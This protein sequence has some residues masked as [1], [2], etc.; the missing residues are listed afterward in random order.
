VNIREEHPWPHSYK[1]FKRAG[2][3]TNG[4]IEWT[5]LSKNAH[6]TKA[7]L[8]PPDEP[9]AIRVAAT[10]VLL[11]APNKRP[12]LMSDVIDVKRIVKKDQQPI[13]ARRHQGGEHWE[14]SATDQCVTSSRWQAL[15]II[16]NRTVLAA[17]HPGGA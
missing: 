11:A 14:S 9:L 13:S 8:P 4:I 5:F 10:A 12:V 1:S 16:S 7:L 15:R 2:I 17:T 3:G 6:R